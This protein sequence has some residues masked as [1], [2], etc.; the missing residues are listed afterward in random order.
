MA[1]GTRQMLLTQQGL[2]MDSAGT[3][4][5]LDVTLHRVAVTAKISHEAEAR[6]DDVFIVRLA[7]VR[8][9]G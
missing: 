6:H 9:G 3:H 4:Q 8:H 1:Y 2:S 5:R 7:V